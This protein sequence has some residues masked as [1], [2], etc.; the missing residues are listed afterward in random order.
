MLKLTKLGYT[1]VYTASFVHPTMGNATWV[2]L[3]HCV[4]G[5]LTD[6]S[7]VM[8]SPAKVAFSVSLQAQA[9]VSWRGTPTR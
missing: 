3:Y 1:V 7:A 8:G 5:P 6:L 2:T 4:I 9:W